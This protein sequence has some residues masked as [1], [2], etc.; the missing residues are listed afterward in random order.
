M[1]TLL[2]I[3]CGTRSEKEKSKSEQS[4][5]D[6]EKLS[7]GEIIKQV[8][9]SGT[10][11]NAQAERLGKVRRSLGLNSLTSIT[12]QQAKS[13]SKIGYLYLNGLTTITDE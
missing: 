11:T 13:P 6:T 5:P 3:G 12:D 7:V 4:S 2:A 10:I 1:L 8:N 9:A